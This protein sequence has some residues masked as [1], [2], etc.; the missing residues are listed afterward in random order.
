M[1]EVEVV[2]AAVAT[3]VA[4]AVRWLMLEAWVAHAQ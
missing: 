3:W 4:A 1:V 2:V